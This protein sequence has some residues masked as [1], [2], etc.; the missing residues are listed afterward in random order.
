[1][2]NI[3][4][5]LD[6]LVWGPSKVG[7]TTLADTAPA[8]R[9]FLDVEMK[10]RFTASRKVAWDPKQY[11]PPTADG[12]W[13]TATVYVRDYSTLEK[14]YEWLNSGQH[15]FKSVALDSITEIQQRAID[16][17]VGADQ[18]KMQDWGTLLRKVSLTIRNFRDLT[19]HPTN[20]LD[21][22]VM[23]AMAKKDEDGWRPLVQGSLSHTLPYLISCCAYYD[24]APDENGVKVRRLFV[25]PIDGY[26]TGENLGGRLGS[27]IDNPNVTEMLKRLRGENKTETKNALNMKKVE[28]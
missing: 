9:L 2:S 16:D 14:A 10:S 21:A 6:I 25:D 28:G 8:P 12:S 13:D 26:V 20:P 22:V 27:Y 19:A 17:L 4:L 18:M 23:T 15:P 3:H 1:M 11:A 5:G 24:F 7:K